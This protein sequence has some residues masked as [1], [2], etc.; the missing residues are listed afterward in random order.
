MNV[1]PEICYGLFAKAG[2]SIPVQIPSEIPVVS[3]SDSEDDELIA[4]TI[5]TK[6]DTK[7]VKDD[8]M[9]IAPNWKSDPKADAGVGHRPSGRSIALHSLAVSP[10]HQGSGFG[11]AIMRAYIKQ[12]QQTAD[13]DR[14]SILTYDRLVPYY[15]NLGFTHYGKSASE[16]AGIAWHD[17]V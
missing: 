8:D 7:V 11:K 1:C 16:Y 9:V 6:S 5:S 14:I 12:I 3:Q 15:K 13:V 4:H 2:T 17:L 10:V